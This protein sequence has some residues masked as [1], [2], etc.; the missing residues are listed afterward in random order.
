MAYIGKLA[1]FLLI[2]MLLT[3]VIFLTDINSNTTT[4]NIFMPV[5]AA[6]DVVV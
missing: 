5:F 1:L 6:M 3:V 2:F 4:A